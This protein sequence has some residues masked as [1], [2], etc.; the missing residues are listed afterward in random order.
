MTSTTYKE[1]VYNYL[2][3]NRKYIPSSEIRGIGGKDGLRRLRE[4]RA[5][6]RNIISRKN[7]K[8]GEWEYRLQGK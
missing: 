7:P 2:R 1:Q 5:E 6:G 4:L 3:K 8:T